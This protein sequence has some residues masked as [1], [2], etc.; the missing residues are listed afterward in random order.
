MLG[1]EAVDQIPGRTE[2]IDEGQEFPVIVDCA[3]TPAALTRCLPASFVSSQSYIDRLPWNHNRVDDPIRALTQ[4]LRV[5]V[6]V[7]VGGWG[8]PSA[9]T[10]GRL[11]GG[12]GAG[13]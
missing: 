7:L 5:R 10:K 6:C 12:G 1:I 4:T 9:S 13:C 11:C 8:S 3:S 2:L